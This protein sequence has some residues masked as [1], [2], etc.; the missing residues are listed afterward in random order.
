VPAPD[1]NLWF[2]EAGYNLRIAVPGAI[3][4]ITPDGTVTEFPI[5]DSTSEPLGITV[6]PDGN[7]WFTEYAGNKI[8]KLADVGFPSRRPRQV[9]FH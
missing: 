3:T 2:T 7:I 4:R 6:G 9:P 5:P 8:A 1:G